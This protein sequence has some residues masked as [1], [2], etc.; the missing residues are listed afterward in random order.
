MF[1]GSLFPKQS[2]LQGRACK[3][4]I[5]SIGQ[6]GPQKFSVLQFDAAVDEVVV[7]PVGSHQ[8]G[9]DLDVVDSR[10]QVQRRR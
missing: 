7:A 4:N 5:H 6:W 2:C 8:V 3:S 10:Q 9:D 1:E